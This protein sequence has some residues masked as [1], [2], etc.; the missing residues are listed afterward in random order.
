MSDTISFTK[1]RKQDRIKKTS[2]EAYSSGY[3]AYFDE[4]FPEN[5]ENDEKAWLKYG[6]GRYVK[7]SGISRGKS[8]VR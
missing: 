3:G 8:A 4:D 5:V 6:T 7:G 2:F 1:G